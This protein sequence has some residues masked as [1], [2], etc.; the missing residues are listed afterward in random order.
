MKLRNKEKQSIHSS[1]CCF[2]L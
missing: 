1:E 2:I